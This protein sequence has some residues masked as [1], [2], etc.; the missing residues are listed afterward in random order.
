MLLSLL[1]FH[2]NP[3]SE[4]YLLSKTDKTKFI[5]DLH[6]EVVQV[7][8][9]KTHFTLN[10]PWSFVHIHFLASPIISDDANYLQNYFNYKDMKP[11]D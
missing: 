5:Q 8:I 9:S 10:E 2:P 11:E 3:N 4:L 7:S 6:K 1:Y